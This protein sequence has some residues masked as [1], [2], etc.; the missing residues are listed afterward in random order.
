MSAAGRLF[1]A[2]DLPAT[3]RDGLAAWARREV[4]HR[5]EM[6]RIPA[7]ALH[8]TLVFL[9][10]RPMTDADRI[11]VAMATAADGPVALGVGAPLWLAPRRPHV[12]T[13][14]IDDPSGAL[15]ALHHGLQAQLGPAIGWEPERRAFRPHVTVARVRRG[16]R[17]RPVELGAPAPMRFGAEAVSLYRS[18]LGGGPARYE[19]VARVEL[20]EPG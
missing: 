19:V 3:V 15:A 12:L 13:V 9:G 1:V 20:P 17:V 14:G 6:R 11:A 5:D 16:A 2:L 4:G 8:L 7:D 18:R 10:N